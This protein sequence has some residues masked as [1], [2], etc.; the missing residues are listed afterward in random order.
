MWLINTHNG[1]KNSEGKRIPPIDINDYPA[2]K[3]H[4]D[5]YWNKL[6]K[7]QDKG[8]THYNL[9]NC[10]Y[11]EEFEKGKIV[12]ME[13]QTDNKKEGYDFPSFAFGM[14]G[15]IV[16]N[17]AYVLTGIGY[18]YI[19]GLLNS[20]LG[21][22]LVKFYVTQLQ[23]RQFRML[24]MY[25]DNFPIPR[26]TKES[27]KPFETLVDKIITKKEHGEDTTAEERQIDIMVYKLYELTYDEVQIV[28]PE[29]ALTKEEY[30]NYK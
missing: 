20:S 9:R 29:F 14:K 16:L 1:Y 8:K 10:S 27:Q 4:L 18:K 23:K 17:T 5:Q 13:I 11:I 6:K 24:A 15:T 12:Y 19:L 22:R 7:R 2:I 28:E 21:E 3:E 26:I 25:V 30:E